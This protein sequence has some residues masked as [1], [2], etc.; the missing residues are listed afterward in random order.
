MIIS[1]GVEKAFDKTQHL[2][3]TKTLIKVGKEGTHLN[4]I[5]AIYD[6]PTVN[7]ILNGRMQKAFLLKSGPRQGGPHSPLLLSSALEVPARATGQEEPKL[8]ESERKR[9]TCHCR[10]ATQCHMQRPLRASHE[11]VRADKSSKASGY[12]I[13][14]QK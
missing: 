7:T 9:Q 8:P 12:K 14:I 3:M 13:N 6:K 4:I 11:T 2:L 10:A 5:K 1:I